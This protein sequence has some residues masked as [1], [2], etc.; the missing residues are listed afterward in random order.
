MREVR[1]SK[2]AEMAKPYSK[3]EDKDKKGDAAQ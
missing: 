3:V 2:A 1:V